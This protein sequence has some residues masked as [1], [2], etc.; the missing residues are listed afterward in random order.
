VLILWE[1]L[2]F[3]YKVFA[4]LLEH[5][6]VVPAAFLVIYLFQLLPPRTHNTALLNEWRGLGLLRYHRTKKAPFKDGAEV[7]HGGGEYHYT[8][9]CNSSD[10][11]I[12]RFV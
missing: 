6:G 1:F 3:I 8:R 7:S 9:N 5:R 2:V 10:T 4:A 12:T 11:P